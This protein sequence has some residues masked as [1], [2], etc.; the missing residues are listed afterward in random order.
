PRRGAFIG[1]LHQ[2]RA[3]AGDD[4][5]VH[6]GE[7]GGRALRFLVPERSGLKPRRS[8][9]RHAIAVAPRRPQPSEV[10]DDVPEAEDRFDQDLSYSIFVGEADVACG[11][12]AGLLSGHAIDTPVQRVDPII[13]AGAAVSL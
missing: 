4:V 1:G 3:A 11:V 5:A 2:P 8:E 9:D 7:P 13:P 12:I 10:V 6:V